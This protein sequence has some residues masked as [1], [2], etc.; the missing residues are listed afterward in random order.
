[1]AAREGGLALTR[2]ELA[3]SA[4]FAVWGL[5]IAIALISVWNVPA[6]LDQLPGGAKAL[7]FDARGPFRWVAGLMLLPILVP[8]LLRPVTR[9]LA[10]GNAWARS[11]AIVAPLIVLWLTTIQRNVWWTI[12]PYALLLAVCVALRR[13]ELQF[14]RR[15]VVLIPTFLTTF[16]ALNDV[17]KSIPAERQIYIA[18]LL[19]FAVRIAIAFLPSRIVPAYAFLLAPL[20]LVL[21]T[22]FFA[23]D[24]R[25]FGWH[26]LALVVLTPFILR[27]VL[28]DARRAAAVLTFVIYPLALYSYSNAMSLATAEG[29]P[30]VNFFEDGH[31]LMPASEYLRGERP[32]RD[33]LPAHGLFEDGLFDTIAM[34]VAGVNAGTR[35][36]VRQMIGNL[37]CVAL[38][39]VA[40]AAT[41]S[42]E[43]AF[44]AV[45][46]CFM[47]GAYTA[48]LRMLPAL[49]TLACIAAGVR[50]RRGRYFAYAG[51][52]TVVCGATSLDFGAY[53][54]LTLLVAVVR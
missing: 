5:A 49:I 19:V 45:L 15:D 50:K 16:L 48:T 39:F 14:T 6:P 22:G 36:K 51:F 38:Y 53:T 3:L 1:M 30:R 9:W 13:R 25:Y 28:R 24:Q 42:A 31:S 23:R 10:A 37:A 2:R 34:K 18:L 20:G 41:G 43:G 46:L 11:T 17:A 33:I 54:F 26:A 12:W 44:F 8:L 47:T 35:T 29:K 52:G 32:Y 21:Q 4:A 27:F 7:N 40:F